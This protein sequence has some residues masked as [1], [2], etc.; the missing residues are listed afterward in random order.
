MLK[1]VG[2]MEKEIEKVLDSWGFGRCF[3]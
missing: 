3:L 1:Y 2:S